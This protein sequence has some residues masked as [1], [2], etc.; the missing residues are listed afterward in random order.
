[1]LVPVVGVLSSWLI[2]DEIPDAVEL[3]AGVAVIG[4]VLYASRMPTRTPIPVTP[5][6]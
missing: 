3:I 2:F 4:G 5:P 1:M 6:T